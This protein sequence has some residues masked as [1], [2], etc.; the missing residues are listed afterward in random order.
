M[1]KI[2]TALDIYGVNNIS[3]L[4]K[5]IDSATFRSR[6]ETNVSIAAYI[7]DNRWVADC[8]HCKS[9]IG[10]LPGYH[11]ATCLDCGRIYRVQLPKKWKT[12]EKIL[13]AR[14]PEHRHWL[15]NETIDDLKQQNYE[16]GLPNEVE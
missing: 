13:L 3:E 16:H 4:E 7:S 6:I 5:R 14:P 10:I 1:I 8:P 9:G 11:K 12:A 2:K 15:P